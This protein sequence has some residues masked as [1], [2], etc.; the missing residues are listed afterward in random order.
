MRLDVYTKVVLTGILGCLIWLCFVL[1]PIGTPV[2]AQ[3]GPTQVV[4]AGYQVGGQTYSLEQGLPVVVTSGT[5]AGTSSPTG[6]VAAPA[7]A[8]PA[9][10]VTSSPRTTPA[11]KQQ[12]ATRCQA[13]TQ[14]G[15]QCSRMASPGSQYCWQHQR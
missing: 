5:A 7:A 6:P 3:I 1:T 13:T 2:S 15:T 9:S 11:P 10:G 8:A 12:T 4:I 14:R